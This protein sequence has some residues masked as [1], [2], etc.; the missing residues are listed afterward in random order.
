MSYLR[1]A[2]ETLTF[3]PSHEA[4]DVMA[5]VLLAILACFKAV[6]MARSFGVLPERRFDGSGQSTVK[7]VGRL[8][9]DSF[10]SIIRHQITD[11]ISPVTSQLALNSQKQIEL[12]TRIATILEERKK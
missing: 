7:N 1:L 5:Y 6:E 10:K 12:L 4:T 9:V 2:S 8:H 11:I 3:P